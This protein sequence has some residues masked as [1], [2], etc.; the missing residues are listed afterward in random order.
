MTVRDGTNPEAG[1]GDII[2]IMKPLQEMILQARFGLG[3]G[4][5]SGPKARKKLCENGVMWLEMDSWG[6]FGRPL[7]ILVTPGVMQFPSIGFSL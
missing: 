7:P 2:Y 5:R 3:K 6:G 4:S 1:G